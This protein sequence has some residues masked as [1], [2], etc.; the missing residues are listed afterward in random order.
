MQMP[1]CSN[2]SSLRLLLVEKPFKFSYFFRPTNGTFLSDY[3]NGDDLHVGV[4]D[5]EGG[6]HEFDEGGVRKQDREE[7]D[8]RWK[9]CLAVDPLKTVDENIV[10]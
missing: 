2:S 8:E 7:E 10:G 9:Q 5:A 4:T 1:F 3:L 6:V